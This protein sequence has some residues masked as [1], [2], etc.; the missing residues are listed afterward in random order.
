ATPG[1]LRHAADP[2]RQPASLRRLRLHGDRRHG[3]AWAVEVDLRVAPVRAQQPDGLVHAGAACPE[4]LAER[5]VLGFLPAHADAQPHA[6]TGLRV[7]SAHAHWASR[8][9]R[10]D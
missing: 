3:I 7:A 4:I 8:V 5:L 1:G 6:P 10:F 2:D 9:A